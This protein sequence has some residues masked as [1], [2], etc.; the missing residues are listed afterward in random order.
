MTMSG[1][2]ED[3]EP[4][5]RRIFF[6][7]DAQRNLVGEFPWAVME[8][9]GTTWRTLGEYG[10]K[11]EAEHSAAYV[12]GVPLR[13]ISVTAK[14]VVVRFGTGAGR[15]R[16]EM[17]AAELAGDIVALAAGIALTRRA[18]RWRRRRRG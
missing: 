6:S 11:A 8:W 18:A 15:G 2:P 9:S 13:T 14:R 4:G 17:S 7:G 5:Q 3:P 10:T 16:V 12:R 1:L